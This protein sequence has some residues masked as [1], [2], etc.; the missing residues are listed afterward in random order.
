MT[1]PGRRRAHAHFLREEA[2]DLRRMAADTSIRHWRD[3]WMKDADRCEEDADWY[4]S[5]ASWGETSVE[6]TRIEPLME[7][8]E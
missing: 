4:D 3:K 6:Y 2:A 7:A 1:T 8:A 5:S